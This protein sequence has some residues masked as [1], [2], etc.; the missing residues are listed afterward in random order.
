M[1]LY[2][3]N[4]NLGEEKYQG[5]DTEARLLFSTPV[6]KLRSTLHW[7]RMLKHDYQRLKGGDW[8]TDL[9]QYN[10]GG[11]VFKDQVKLIFN[12]DYGPL[13]HTF[14]TNW[15]S[16]YRDYQCTAADCGLV[17]I[18]HADGT[19]G[20]AVDMTDH[21]V[22]AFYTFD[23]QTR[24]K[25]DK[26]LNLTLGVLNLTNRNPP[27][28]IQQDAGHQVGYDNRYADPRGRV[29]YGALNYKF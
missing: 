24:Y 8:F 17:R 10:D 16:G 19:F 4:E 25:F 2:L 20:S 29:I 3:P 14:T 12:L 21:H 15:K 11:V 22:D 23:W 28:T 27:F 6:G 26:Q 5:I 1:A 9:G 13:E 18:L 7:T